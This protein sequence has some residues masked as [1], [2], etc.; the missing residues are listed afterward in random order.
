M[1]NVT[2]K[3]EAVKHHAASG[4]TWIKLTGDEDFEWVLANHPDTPE[5][6]VSIGGANN[7]SFRLLEKTTFEKISVQSQGRTMCVVS[8]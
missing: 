1:I 6:F 4:R 7:G 2:F 3:L 8:A 5:G